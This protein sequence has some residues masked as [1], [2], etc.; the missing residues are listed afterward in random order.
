MKNVN[1]FKK[2]A[3]GAALT[4]SLGFASSSAMAFE[5]FNVDPTGVSGGAGAVFTADK[6]TGNYVEVISFNFLDATSGTFDVSLRWNAGQFVADDGVNVVAP[7]TNRLGFDYGL[8]ALYEGTGTFNIGAG[9]VTNF[10]SNAGSGSLS[11]WIDDDVDSTFMAPASGA[12]AWTIGNNAD[13]ILIA[14]GTPGTGGGVLDPTL[15]TCGGGAINCGSFGNSTSF[16]LTAAGSTFFTAPNPFYSM[17]F[18]SGQLNNFAVAGTQ[19]INGSLDVVFR[20]VPAPTSI[21]LMGLGLSLLGFGARRR[22]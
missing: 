22:K 3:A 7:L 19:V 6:I 13:D 16:G 1:I 17:S 18:Q 11:M 5:D 4:A 9:G 15:A 8:Y 20:G 14:T 21:A 12:A 2:I 10:S